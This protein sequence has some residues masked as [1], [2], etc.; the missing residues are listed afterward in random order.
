MAAG[1]RDSVIAASWYREPTSRNSI[2]TGG[3]AAVPAVVGVP[4]LHPANR[5]SGASRMIQN[6]LV[7]SVAIRPSEKGEGPQHRSR[8]AAHIRHSDLGL[9]GDRLAAEPGA[10]RL[11]DGQGDVVA[12]E[13]DRPVTE[14]DV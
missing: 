4:L 14:S 10:H 11:P 12:D 6:R 7:P 3:T 2:A 1:G 13:P 9:A 8:C 5:P